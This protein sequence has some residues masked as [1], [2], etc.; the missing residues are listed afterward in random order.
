LAPAPTVIF[1]VDVPGPGAAM[2]EGVKLAVTSCG[3]PDA[4]REMGELK[5]PVAMIA[6]APEPA[7]LTVSELGVA[8]RLKLVPP[9][10][11]VTVRNTVV[12]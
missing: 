7:Q 5:T 2:D 6:V 8:L 10:A 4:D 9:P 3:S 12:V 1:I 11:A